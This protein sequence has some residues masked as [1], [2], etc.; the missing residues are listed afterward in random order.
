MAILNQI[1]QRGLFLVIVIALALFSFVLADV[2]KNSGDFSSKSQN[3]IATINGEDIK[4][5]D[6]MNKVEAI[7]RQSGGRGTSTQAMNQAWDQ[8]IRKEVME[9]QYNALALVIERDQMRDL[10][11]QSLFSFEEF[12]DA[13]GLFDENK[14]NEFIANLKAI[15]PESTLLNGSP[16]NYLAWTNYESTISAGGRQQTYFNMVKAGIIGTLA[17][18]ELE[19]KLENDKVDIKFVQIPFSSIPDS[20]IA[21]SKSD[22]TN[23]INKN[24]SKYEVSASRDI[25]FVHFK[26]E[27]SLEDESNLKIELQDLL[28]DRVKYNVNSKSNDTILGFKNTTDNEAFVN[29]NSAIK[30]NNSFVTKSLM[31]TKLADSL[32]HLA[33]GSFYGPYKQGNY[34]MLSKIVEEKHLPDS[35]K[36]RHIL[37]P[38]VG[39]ASADLSVTQSEEEAKK[40]ADSVLN[41]VKRNRFKFSELVTA[42]SSDRSSIENEGRY[43][44][45]PYNAMVPQFRD[46]TFENNTGDIAV[47]KTDFG[48]H[49]IE[50]EGQKNKQRALKIATLAQQIEPSEHTID[51]IFNQASKF[52]IAIASQDFQDV[53]KES[54]YSVRPVSSIGELDESIP[55]LGNQRA[56]VRWSFEDA[57]NVGD[58]KRFNLQGGGYTVVMLTAI[59]KEGL[60]S[61]QK[62]SVT[63]L[64]EIRKQKKAEL[65]KARITGSTLEEIAA[66]E[67]QTVKTALAVNMK[68]PT[69]S[70]AGREPRVIGTAFGLNEGE[71]SNPI[72]GNLG[73][74]FVQTTKI[75]PAEGQTNYQAAANRVGVTKVNA[76]NTTLYNALKNA[77]EIDDN[78]A[79]FY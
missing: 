67:N 18:G 20:T 11:K 7:Q 62:A 21:V 5:D 61:T 24:K 39:A 48:F 68:S 37:I 78:R 74:Y 52:E 44:W 66:S 56:M 6:F 59:N 38:F 47:V 10:L 45:H 55:G 69:L 36:V 13:D 27:A 63:A 40:T 19:Y 46:F 65:I 26:E 49:I 43:D 57:T 58:I 8:V 60:M 34:Y 64:P 71:I 28:E 53:A 33:K 12:K 42:L 25:Y 16:I 30:F 54:N 79:T 76:V 4:R 72:V 70:G 77:S 73:V 9:S 51:I 1:R 32:Y 22:I 2:F 35:V 41:V 50:I 14:L 75:T 17:E 29:A 31:P 23:Y 15:S 3:I